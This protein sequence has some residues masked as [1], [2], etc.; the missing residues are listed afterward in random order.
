MHSVT[1]KKNNTFYAHMTLMQCL[2]L[3]RET[4][5]HTKWFI[6]IKIIFS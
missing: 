3:L 5:L 6:E 4:I 1:K 2:Q